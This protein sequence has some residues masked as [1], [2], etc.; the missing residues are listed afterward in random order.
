MVQYTKNKPKV[1]FNILCPYCNQ[2]YLELLF[3]KTGKCSECGEKIEVT[4]VPLEKKRSKYTKTTTLT[5]QVIYEKP[6]KKKEEVP[7]LKPET[8]KTSNENMKPLNK[9]R[10]AAD[11]EPQK[12][13]KKQEVSHKEPLVHENDS[14]TET[15][16]ERDSQEEQNEIVDDLSLLG[17]KGFDNESDES[18]PTSSSDNVP[19]TVPYKK[20]SVK[21]SKNE[22]S[23]H[24]EKSEMTNNVS[25]LLSSEEKT[26]KTNKAHDEPYDEA[27]DSE[28]KGVP[29]KK[30]SCAEW[31]KERKEQKIERQK[32][33]LE[34]DYP[35]KFNEDGFYD[36]TEA[37][38]E[39][40]PDVI[41]KTILIK[42]LGIIVALFLLISFLVYYA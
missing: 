22:D 36:D 32:E 14:Q 24:E 11:E 13:D 21:E 16:Y 7:K 41:G 26:E 31:L 3:R 10:M 35:F 40:R 38:A 17:L 8:Q 42:G 25:E 27:E 1:V 33:T 5:P 29:K 4:E 30:L 28:E 18:S 34:T 23:F 12:T 37:M 39:A 2:Q 15:V 19:L 20:E 6:E 9:Q